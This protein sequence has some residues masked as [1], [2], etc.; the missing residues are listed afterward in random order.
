M[1][2]PSATGG[3]T[4]EEV[5]YFEARAAALNRPRPAA[6][7]EARRGYTRRTVASAGITCSQRQA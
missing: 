1:R 5:G 6:A 2:L 4:T 3:A 7:P